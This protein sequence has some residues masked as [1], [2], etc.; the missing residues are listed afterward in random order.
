MGKRGM[1][2]SIDPDLAQEQ[3]L[4]DRESG[5]GVPGLFE[6][7]AAYYARYRSK[8]PVAMF[9]HMVDRFNLGPRYSVLDLGC[10]TGQLALP[11]SERQIPVYA[12]DPEI[13]MLQEGI[14]IAR[15]SEISGTRWMLGSDRTIDSLNLPLLRLC[16][17]GSSFHW[18]NRGPLLNAL[19]PLIDDEGGIAVISERSSVWGTQVREPWEDVIKQ[20]VQEFLGQERCAAGGTYSHPTDKHQVV[21]K[22]SS[23]RVVEELEFSVRQTRTIEQVIGLQLSTS[24]ASIRQLGSRVEEFKKT[25]AERLREAVPSEEFEKVSNTEVLI[26][27]RT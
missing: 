6:G 17:M 16:V 14:R 11:L 3:G 24:Y 5:K 22:R 8:Y 1:L 4:K 19:E 15:D 23:F 12:V 27:T 21:L 13:E 10:G 25:L 2:L 7:T 18:T 20:V 9:D 26:A